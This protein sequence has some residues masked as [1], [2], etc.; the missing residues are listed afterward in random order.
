MLLTAPWTIS[1]TA[2]PASDPTGHEPLL[3]SY[4]KRTGSNCPPMMGAGFNPIQ[5]SRMVV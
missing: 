5:S 3:A 2:H 1:D 4:R